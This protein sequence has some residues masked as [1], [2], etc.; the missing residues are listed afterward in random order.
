MNIRTGGEWSPTDQMPWSCQS[1][2]KLQETRV[3]TTWSA[4]PHRGDTGN[5]KAT[6]RKHAPSALQHLC[7]KRTSS[8]LPRDP[9]KL[10]FPFLCSFT[11]ARTCF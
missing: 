7:M 10:C 4:Y 1:P 9:S 8:S 2:V 5:A 6:P 3:D 11:S